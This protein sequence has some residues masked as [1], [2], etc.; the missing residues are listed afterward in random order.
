MRRSTA[1]P[2]GAALL[3]V[4][5]GAQETPAAQAKVMRGGKIAHIDM[6]PVGSDKTVTIRASLDRFAT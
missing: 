4:A 6:T 2:V 3:A 5:A 1:A